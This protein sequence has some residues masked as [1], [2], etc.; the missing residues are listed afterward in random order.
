MGVF[1]LLHLP[2]PSEGGMLCNGHPREGKLRHGAG[3]RGPSPCFAGWGQGRAASKP[4]S[5][6]AMWLEEPPPNWD[7][8]AVGCLAAADLVPLVGN[9]PAW[10][11]REENV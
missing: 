9:K 7:S 10:S 4:S 3:G 5:T 11:A 2:Q 1:L 8:G 6:I